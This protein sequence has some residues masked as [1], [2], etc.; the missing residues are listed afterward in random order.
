MTHEII[1]ALDLITEVKRVGDCGHALELQ[2][3][4]FNIFREIQILINQENLLHWLSEK[5]L[6]QFSHHA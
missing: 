5:D 1:F 6:E 3:Q 2:A 4:L